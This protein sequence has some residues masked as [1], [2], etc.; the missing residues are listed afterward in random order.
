MSDKL[1]HLFYI[2]RNT[3]NEEQA[4]IYLR[5]IY[6]GKRAE[7]SVNQKISIHLWNP[8]SGRAKGNSGE[9]QRVNRHLNRVENKVQQ[10]FQTLV[11][12]NQPLTAK[13]VI[14][15]YSGKKEKHKMLLEIF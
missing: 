3:K 13:H 8:N 15:L 7:I 11:N 6:E 5:I 10:C 9:S 2:R 4:A 12:K 1:Y 14:D